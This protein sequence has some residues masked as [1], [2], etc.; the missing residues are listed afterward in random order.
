MRE[1]PYRTEKLISGLDFITSV[2]AKAPVTYGRESV[3]R[4][5][6]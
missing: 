1:K 5:K 2:E 4:G 6:D 3:M